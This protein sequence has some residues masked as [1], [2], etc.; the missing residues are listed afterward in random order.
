MQA[1]PILA[2][3]SGICEEFFGGYCPLGDRCTR[4]HVEDVDE[5]LTNP[6]LANPLISLVHSSSHH[7][8]VGAENTPSADDIRSANAQVQPPSRISNHS[9][10]RDAAT[11]I[12]FSEYTVPQSTST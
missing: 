2:L 10:K 7:A 8:V 5:T 9:L 6:S 1:D 4:A 3:P 11:S 12:Q